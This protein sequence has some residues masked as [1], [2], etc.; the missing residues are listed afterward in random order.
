[1]PKE[2]ACARILRDVAVESLYEPSAEE[3]S[4][5]APAERANQKQSSRISFPSAIPG[6]ERASPSCG[7]ANSLAGILD[8][9]VEGR[10][11]ESRQVAGLI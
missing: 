7:L 6:E 8:A 5:G 3:G 2:D 9:A 10:Q 1:M 11:T 4:A